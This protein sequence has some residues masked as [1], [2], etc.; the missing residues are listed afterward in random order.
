MDSLNLKKLSLGALLIALGSSQY[1]SVTIPT[2]GTIYQTTV[3]NNVIIGGYNYVSGDAN[4][5]AGYYN[6]L[7]G[8]YN[9]IQGNLNLLGG[10]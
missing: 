1:G 9:T 5:L 8:S 2:S 10:Y 3:P 4:Q 6:T 7:S